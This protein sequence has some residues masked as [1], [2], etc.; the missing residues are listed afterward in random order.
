M[1]DHSGTNH[2]LSLI[3]LSYWMLRKNTTVKKVLSW[4]ITCQWM[5]GSP[6]PQ[7]TADLPEDWLVTGPTDLH[8]RWQTALDSSLSEGGSYKNQLC[9]EHQSNTYKELRWSWIEGGAPGMACKQLS[10]RYWM[11]LWE[12]YSWEGV[13][14]RLIRNMGKVFGELPC[15]Q[16][17]DDECMSRLFCKEE[18]SMNNTTRY[19]VIQLKF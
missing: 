5:K 2:T 18:S 6:L 19:P 3:C 11:T 13:W 1:P 4:C 17:F 14:E 9:P 7:H 12:H 15:Q 10:T 16:V 8:S